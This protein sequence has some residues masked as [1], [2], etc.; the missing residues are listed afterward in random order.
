MTKATTNENDKID[1]IEWLRALL[2]ERPHSV[3][4]LGR[5]ARAQG[6]AQADVLIAGLSMGVLMRP[7]RVCATWSLPTE[8]K[9]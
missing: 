1:P 9:S 6:I 5:L 3:A 8:G 4:E 7:G 2:T